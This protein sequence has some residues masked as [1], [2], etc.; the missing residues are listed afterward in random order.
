MCEYPQYGFL[1]SKQCDNCNESCDHR[2]GCPESEKTSYLLTV[3]QSQWEMTTMTI[4]STDK[5]SIMPNVTES[6]QT[7]KQSSNELNRKLRIS[8][9]TLVCN[10]GF[11]GRNCS[12]MCEYPQ[13]GFLCSKQCDNCNE[14]CDHRT[15][16]PESEKTSYLFTVSQSQWELTTV[17]IQSTDK[18]SIMPNVTE[19]VQTRKQSSNE[20]NRKLRI[21]VTTLGTTCA[22]L[23][24]VYFG[25]LLRDKLSTRNNLI[26][27][28]DLSDVENAHQNMLGP[29]IVT[30]T[31]E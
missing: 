1:C 18:D 24:M 28:N 31:F 8:V 15:G 16:C 4:Q 14:S 17:T 13:Y 10:P 25:W 23:Y 5:D 27:T 9:T 30:I 26:T 21:S 2:T 11:T 22:V 19:S 6:A 3:S 20:L 7:R 12:F 29:D